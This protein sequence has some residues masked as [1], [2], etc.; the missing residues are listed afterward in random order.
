MSVHRVGRRTAR[1]ETFQK[2]GEGIDEI[3]RPSDSS[4]LV[5][6]I[7]PSYLRPAEVKTLLGDPT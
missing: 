3:G 2:E 4:E 1:L 6:C 5:V 7:A